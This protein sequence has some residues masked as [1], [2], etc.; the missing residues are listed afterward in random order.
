MRNTEQANSTT[1]VWTGRGLLNPRR[2]IKHPEVTANISRKTTKGR[3]ECSDFDCARS[4]ISS[5]IGAKRIANR[6]T[7]DRRNHHLCNIKPGWSDARYSYDLPGNNGVST[8]SERS[9][10]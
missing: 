7:C 4:C 3:R 6:R 10:S 8:Q 1:N 5:W 9:Y 2:A